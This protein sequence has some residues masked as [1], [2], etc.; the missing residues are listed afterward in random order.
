MNLAL[1]A[2]DDKSNP[3]ASTSVADHPDKG[4]LQEALDEL[5]RQAQWRLVEAPEAA[6]KEAEA[7]VKNQQKDAEEAAAEQQAQIEAQ[8][9][10]D[11]QRRLTASLANAPVPPKEQPK[12]QPKS[13]PQK[14]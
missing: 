3:V 10:L 9:V 11:E 6:A 13:V 12:E 8:Q 7:R 1:I 4:A 2:D 14:A 5:A